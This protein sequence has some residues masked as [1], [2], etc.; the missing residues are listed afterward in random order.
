MQS[1]A[2]FTA[3]IRQ[4]SLLKDKTRRIMKDKTS[5]CCSS[6]NGCY[7]IACSGACDLGNI[8]DHVARKLSREGFRKMHCLALVGAGIDEPTGILKKSNLLVLDGCNVE[9]GKKIV[10]KAGFR[11]FYYLKVTELGYEKGKTGVTASSINAVF[12]IAQR[13]N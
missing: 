9:C 11:D 5:P 2:C 6:K 13:L 1:A 3:R 12:K 7:V 4:E 10:Q 8:T